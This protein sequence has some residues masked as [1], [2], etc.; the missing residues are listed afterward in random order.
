MDNLYFPR[1]TKLN[2]F[3]L[4]WNLQPELQMKK[5]L[6][7]KHNMYLIDS[8]GGGF[9]SIKNPEKS[10]YYSIL[11]YKLSLIIN[12]QET[13]IK[14]MIYYGYSLFWKN[15][16]KNALKVL[17]KAKKLSENNNNKLLINRCDSALNKLFTINFL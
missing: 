17:V 16:Y 2:F 11:L 15:K 9:A 1:R 5:Y 7:I 3:Y 4:Y 8:I 6:F 10:L 12:D 14:C 13:M